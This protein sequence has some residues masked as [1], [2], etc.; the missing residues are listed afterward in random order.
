MINRPDVCIL[1]P[2][3][4][5]Y[6]DMARFTKRMLD[7]F[8]P[9]HPHVFLCGVPGFGAGQGFLLSRAD[10][11]DWMGGVLDA[12]REL[13][14]RGFS[15]V[16]LILDDHPPFGPCHAHHLNETLPALAAE[17][18]AACISLHGWGEG[19]LPVT[20]ERLD[21]KHYRME[22]LPLSQLWKFSLHPALWSLDVLEGICETLS[23]GAALPA[24]SA[25]AFERRAGAPDAPLPE[26]WTRN[27]YRI[28]GTAMTGW[29]DG[30]RWSRLWLER[31]WCHLVRRI[32]A[33]ANRM[34]ALARFDA[35]TTFLFQFYVGPYPHYHSGVL[36]KGGV[37]REAAA[38]LMMHGP[39]IMRRELAAI[40][41]RLDHA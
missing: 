11:R 1:I 4:A 32:L 36:T 21:R 37:S 15:R 5:R 20:G 41:K 13:R 6:V 14:A 17:L 22:R 28:S 2:T 29:T 39:W 30:L 25:W 31:G 12:T 38:Y 19:R 33:R 26:A 40:T 3:C 16:Y 34:E 35:A 23:R 7:R 18:Q 10:P 9:R 24:R 8:W 27:T